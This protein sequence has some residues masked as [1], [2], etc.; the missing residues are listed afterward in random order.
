MYLECKP[1][2]LVDYEC[3]DLVTETGRKLE[4][5]VAKRRAPYFSPNCATVV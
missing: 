3:A 1:L 4:M 5:T 2:I